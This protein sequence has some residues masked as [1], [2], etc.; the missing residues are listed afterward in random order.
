MGMLTTESESKKG[1]YEAYSVYFS[2][3]DKETE[4]KNLLKAIDSFKMRNRRSP[5]SAEVEGIEAFLSTNKDTSLVQFKLSVISDEEEQEQKKK[6]NE[7]LL[8]TPVKKKK[9]AARFNVYFDDK[10][11]NTETALKWFERFNNRK[12]TKLEMS[13]IE[14]FIRTDKSELIECEFEVSAFDISKAE[15]Q[16]FDDDDCKYSDEERALKMKT[17]KAVKKKTSTTYTLD[18]EDKSMRESGDVK[19]ALKWFERFNSRQANKEERARIS[20]FVKAD[21]EQ[22]IN[23]D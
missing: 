15:S 4:R 1:K 13:G 3:F 6:K 18:F 9:D 14:S 23:I 20:Q 17:S 16:L 21:N 11:V 8:I 22:M 10:E 5:T 2:R 12:P 7:K 19:Q